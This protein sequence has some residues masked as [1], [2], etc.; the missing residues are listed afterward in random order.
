VPQPAWV[1]P[2]AT[3]AGWHDTSAPLGVPG[4]TVIN[5]HNWPENGIF[6]NLYKVE[7]GSLV[8]IYAG[9]RVFDYEV[10]DAVIVKEAGQPLE[11]RQANAHRLMPTDDE[12]VTIVTCHPY[13][14]TRNRLIVTARPVAQSG[15]DIRRRERDPL[16]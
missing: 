4:N 13:A 2:E 6:R 8:V 11:V 15:R 10:V 1:V 12:R 3:R 9:D 7:L 14:S 5:G 16:P